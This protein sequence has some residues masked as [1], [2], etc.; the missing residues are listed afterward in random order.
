MYDVM[1][2]SAY[3]AHAVNACLDD[4]ALLQAMLD[5]EAALAAACA[6]VGLVPHTAAA[7]IA[8][9]C[10]AEFFD[11]AAIGERTVYHATPVVPLVDD[12]RSALPED[13]RRYVHLGATSQ[14]ILD[15]A[16][17]IILRDALRAVLTDLDAVAEVLAFLADRHAADIQI[18]R[19]LLQ[20]AEP[21][22][23]GLVCAGW[24]TAVD[25]A[26]V[27]LARIAGERMAA[28]VGCAVGNRAAYGPHGPAIAREV[29]R[30]LDLVDPVLPWHADRQ[31]PAELATAVAL[32]SGALA[33]IAR[34]VVLLAQTEVAEVSEG[35][36]GG[37]SAMP[38]KRN[39][40]RAVL[41]LAGTR[42]IPP[43]A[44]TMLSS[45]DG[46]AQRAAGSWQAELP[47]LR[48]IVALLGGAAVNTRDLLTGLRVDTARMR[49]TVEGRPADQR[50]SAPADATMVAAAGT[51]IARALAAHREVSN[52]L[53]TQ[54]R[55][56]G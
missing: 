6:R 24:M 48:R 51:L 23:F 44:E 17:S 31:R 10:Q 47:A 34:N 12:L 50:Q 15:T 40:A 41:V 36:A 54:P 20:H 37:S 3:T 5:V 19:T 46:E 33:T 38:H 26:R 25:D 56:D 7:T 11:T 9:R 27:R 49:A 35:S 2:R 22:T 8:A 55:E 52:A 4:H 18:G 28:Q 1:Y 13:I 21:T 32:A 39:P 45:M 53:G 43:L 42:A 16:T 14:D 29:A 30:L